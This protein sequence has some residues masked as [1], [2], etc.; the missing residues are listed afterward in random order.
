MEPSVPD[1]KSRFL[2]P[3]LPAR[4]PTHGSDQRELA[5]LQNGENRIGSLVHLSV[6]FSPGMT[7]WR[8]VGTG[9]QNSWILSPASDLTGSVTLGRSPHFSG[10]LGRCTVDTMPSNLLIL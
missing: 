9:C 4:V 7:S 1:C 3:I 5:K 8:S 10:S 6:D 2:H